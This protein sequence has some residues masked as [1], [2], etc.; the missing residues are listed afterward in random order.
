M[1]GPHSPYYSLAESLYLAII[2]EQYDGSHIALTITLYL[3]LYLDI[4]MERYE[5]PH[6][7]LTIALH[8]DLY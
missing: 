6:T 1:K 8:E 4:I 2:M 3:G 7:S 5:G